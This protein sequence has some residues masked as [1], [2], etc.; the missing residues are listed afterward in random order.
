[1]RK[2]LVPLLMLCLSVPG[3]AQGGK[4]AK[5]AGKA[6]VQKPSKVVRNISSKELLARYQLYAQSI[7][8]LQQVHAQQAAAALID[9]QL[10]QAARMAYLEKLNAE[11]AAALSELTANMKKE[12]AKWADVLLRERNAKYLPKKDPAIPG[13]LA[14]SP[15][16]L[17]QPHMTPRFYREWLDTIPEYEDLPEEFSGLVFALRKKLHTMDVEV[18]QAVRAY[19]KAKV[20]LDPTD[21]AVSRYYRK[22]MREANRELLRL[23]KESAQC[24]ADLVYL[25]NLYPT[26]FKDSLKL[27]A[28]QLD[29]SMQTEFTTY[30]RARIKEPKKKFLNARPVGFN[31]NSAPNEPMKGTTFNGFKQ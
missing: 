27:L 1:M 26:L 30:L 22:Q 17:R 3:F 11:S 5:T 31:N 25:L 16:P 18:V 15:D 13:L 12:Y 7:R 28:N 9:P 8:T 21:E 10:E 14:F 29:T 24:V 2:V 19:M 4:L 23:S 6:L 20:R